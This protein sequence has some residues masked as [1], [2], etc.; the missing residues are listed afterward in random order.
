MGYRRKWVIV[1]LLWLLI[2]RHA[3][4]FVQLGGLT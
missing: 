3:S 1:C 4:D 2:E